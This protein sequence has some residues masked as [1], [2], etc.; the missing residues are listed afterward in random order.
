[1]ILIYNFEK[2]NNIQYSPIMNENEFTDAVTRINKAFRDFLSS[3]D[4]PS[5]ISNQVQYAIK[6]QNEYMSKYFDNSSGSSN[7][8]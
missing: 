3:G 7:P 6:V 2:N 8:G 5:E 1:M 4:Y